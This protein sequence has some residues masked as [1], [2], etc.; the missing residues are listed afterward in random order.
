MT[1]TTTDTIAIRSLIDR[2]MGLDARLRIA[3]ACN[4]GEY[5]EEAEKIRV[6]KEI[7][8]LLRGRWI[9]HRGIEW[10]EDR[11]QFPRVLSRIHP[12]S[13]WNAKA[14]DDNRKRLLAGREEV[15]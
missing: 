1:T 15:R 11:E 7:C 10:F 14:D 13:R 5:P 4:T 9:K 12:G 2:W 3:G 6:G 8:A